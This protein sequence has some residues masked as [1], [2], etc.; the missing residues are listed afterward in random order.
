MSNPLKT[1]VRYSGVPCPRCSTRLS[2]V[3]ESRPTN[4]NRR[5]RR[6]CAKGHRYWTVEAVI[7]K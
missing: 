2:K 5:R 7:S 1:S 4:V 3:I 6:E